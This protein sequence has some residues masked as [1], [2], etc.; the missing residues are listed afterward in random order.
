MKSRLLFLFCLL[1]FVSEGWAEHTDVK[2]DKKEESLYEDDRDAGFVP[3]IV[4]DGHSLCFSSDYSIGYVQVS[5][6]DE[7]DIVVVWDTFA[8]FG[9]QEYSL[10]LPENV[11]GMCLLEM[12]VEKTEYWGWFDASV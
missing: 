12:T 8:L 2:L 1:A 10:S 9:G 6:K 4:Y 5:V 3:R 11:S 7:A